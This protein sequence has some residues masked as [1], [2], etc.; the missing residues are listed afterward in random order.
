M[1]KRNQ[2]GIEEKMASENRNI[3]TSTHLTIE[4][5]FIKEEGLEQ[6][7]ENYKS[8]LLAL[9]R[10][11]KTFQ[12]D[13]FSR[14]NKS[15]KIKILKKSLNTLKESLAK[16]NRE[17]TRQYNALKVAKEDSIMRKQEI[18]FPENDNDNKNY[19]Y[20]LCSSYIK[21]KIELNYINFQLE[22]EIQKTDILIG[23]KNKTYLYL[24][25]ITFYLNLNREI[26]CKINQEDTEIVSEILKNIRTLVKN[27]FISVVKEKMETDLEIDSVTSKIK[28][29][30]DNIIKYKKGDNKYVNEDEIIYEDTKEDNKTLFINNQNKRNTCANINKIGFN[31]NLLKRPSN[32]LAK[33]HLSI[34]EALEDNFYRN[35]ILE[36]FLKNN[37][38]MNNNINQ[39][40]NFL[41]INVNINL[42]NNKY[43]CSSSSS[44]NEEGCKNNQNVN[45]SSD[46]SSNKS[47]E[48][49]KE[50]ND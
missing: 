4:K 37:D 33:K 13:Y 36:L 46:I 32:N 19:E 9:F 27:E 14:E 16:M 39:I 48:E 15:N 25:H 41:N 43:N 47:E 12:N 34:D 8:S 38:F 18:L 2:I 17:K 42:G 40:N 28:T 21:K 20:D 23:I 29:M 30:N 5:D 45:I 49:I 31:K 11:I 3:F 22:N 35:K 1:K 6:I 24:K 44:E 26:F 50:N 7:L 10:P